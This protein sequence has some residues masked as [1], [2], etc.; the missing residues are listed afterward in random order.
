MYV[1]P[2][3]YLYI[4]RTYTTVV[5]S[6][7]TYIY[8]LFIY[9]VQYVQYVQYVFECMNVYSLTRSAQRESVFSSHT[10]KALLTL[11]G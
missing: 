6:T 2:V 8:T 11:T 1:Y 3:L 5:R 10:V 4:P 7:G 9:D